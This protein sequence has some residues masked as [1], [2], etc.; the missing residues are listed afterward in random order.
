M[1]PRKKSPPQEKKREEPE[2][3]NEIAEQISSAVDVAET[4]QSVLNCVSTAN[5]VTMN[6]SEL[7]E[8]IAADLNPDESAALQAY[9]EANLVASAT[10]EIHSQ[11]ELAT[12]EEQPELGY[13]SDSSDTDTMMMASGVK[14]KNLKRK[15]LAKGSNL[16]DASTKEKENENKALA[17]VLEDMM[18]EII[19]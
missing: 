3:T 15:S 14:G 13:Q 9:V 17:P 18:E 2:P 7:A 10:P 4:V 16:T 5:P 6:T 1:Q 8:S 11:Y 12:I 19:D